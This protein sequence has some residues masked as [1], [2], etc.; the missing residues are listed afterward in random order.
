MVTLDGALAASSTLIAVA[1]SA[2]T[3][4]RWLARRRPHDLAW[5]VSLAMFAFA[6]GAF[7]WGVSAGWSDP[8]FR[9]FYL[10][11][12]IANVPYLAL[13]SIYLLYGRRLGD[14]VAA[15]VTAACLF[16]AGVIT[17]A[18]VRHAVAA[19]GLPQGSEVFGPLP[20]VLAAV[21][22]GVAA[23][24]VIVLAVL[25][26]VRLVRHRPGAWAP[27]LALGNAVIAAGTLVLGASGTLAGS[28]GD[29]RAFAVTLTAGIAILFAG[30]VVATSATA[31]RSRA[32]T[33][34]G[35]APS[36]PEPPARLR[37]ARA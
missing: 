26:A 15:A 8:V 25:S 29:V 3:Y 1:F 19:T 18:P 7:W 16:A 12:A 13:G 35:T 2:A 30:F 6:A 5:S 24:V 14:R 32:G 22:S 11:G 27:R 33:G 37:P 34:T 21:S 9:C 31:S 28:L 36:A 23:T 4:E 10:F 20:R 17:V